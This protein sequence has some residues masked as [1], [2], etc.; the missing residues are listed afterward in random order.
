MMKR[1]I[2]VLI[3]VAGLNGCGAE[4]P[5]DVYWMANQCLQ[6][7]TDGREVYGSDGSYYLA[8]TSGQADPFFFKPS[9]LGQYMLFDAGARWLAA[10][11]TVWAMGEPQLSRGAIWQAHLSA[12]D[13][14]RFRSSESG[15][16]LSVQGGQL[17]TA[18]DE[19]DATLFT[20]QAA[21]GCADFPEA[22]T[23]ASGEPDRSHFD[24]GAVWGMADVHNHLF[25]SMAFAGNVM[26]GDVFHPLG[27]TRALQDCRA[28][29]GV[30]GWLDI[31]GFVTG[32]R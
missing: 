3:L 20:L 12:G 16:W 4:A 13:G 23:N 5:N 19:A 2:G 7:H 18:T 17:V 31:T 29:H 30:N 6:M 24:D 25:G 21:E 9:A 26:A 1:L 15:H 22:D 11:E 14:Y 27:I 8:E 28:E 32:G 10:G